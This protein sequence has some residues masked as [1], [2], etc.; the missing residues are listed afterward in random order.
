MRLVITTEGEQLRQEF[1]K[2][3]QMSRLHNPSLDQSIHDFQTHTLSPLNG[4]K[5]GGKYA[6]VRASVSLGNPLKTAGR[7]IMNN[8]YRSFL[9]GTDTDGSIQRASEGLRGPKRGLSMLP[10]MPINANI[11]NIQEIQVAQKRPRLS[12]ELKS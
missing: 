4:L 5:S 9:Q 12:K 8:E 2:D 6:A 10:S 1:L 11:G 3:Y 7:N